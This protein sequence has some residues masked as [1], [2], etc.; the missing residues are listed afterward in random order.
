MWKNVHL[1]LTKYMSKIVH[2]FQVLM[3]QIK[4]CK[5]LNKNKN[6]NKIFPMFF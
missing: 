2:S 3:P 1:L 4:R 6:K 5:L